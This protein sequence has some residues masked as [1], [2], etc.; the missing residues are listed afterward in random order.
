[1]EQGSNK[2]LFVLIAIVIF[3]IFLSLSYW[4][5]QDEMKGVLADVM[6]KTSQV[7][8]TFM[9][10]PVKP[11]PNPETDFDFDIATGTIL[12]YKGTRTDLVIPETIQGVVVKTIDNDAFRNK[13]LTSVIIADTVTLIQNGAY[14]GGYYGAFSDNPLLTMVDLGDGLVT[15]GEYAFYKSGI[16]DIIFPSSSLVTI[17]YCAFQI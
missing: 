5:F 17:D 11:I 8:G 12:N 7:A 14:S 15:I 9:N 4:M 13:G 10:E 16:I 6:E 2:S 1:M 3:G